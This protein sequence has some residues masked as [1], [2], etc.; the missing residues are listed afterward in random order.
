MDASTAL[1]GGLAL[2]L[3]VKA[4]SKIFDLVSL[5][6]APLIIFS[7]KGLGKTKSLDKTI[8]FKD[9]FLLLPHSLRNL[10]KAFG[11]TMAKGYF[12]FLLSDINYTGI[13][14]KFEYWTGISLNEYSK[15]A[16]E[17]KH[18]FWSFKLES[19]KY[20]KLDCQCLHELLTKFNELIYSNFKINIHKTLTLPSLAMKIYK[21]H[22][23]PKDSIY[24]IVQSKVEAAIRDSYTGGAVEC[25]H[26]TALRAQ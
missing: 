20:C 4:I 18:K 22:Y 8:T 9:S 6:T 21:R 23:M 1:R 10:C 2:I 26:S 12:P 25:I 19:I 17:H 11:I 16:L 24:Q 5:L 3:S 13:F 15:L 7:S 14:P